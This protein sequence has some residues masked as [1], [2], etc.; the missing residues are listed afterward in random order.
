MQTGSHGPSG[1]STSKSAD[2]DDREVQSV[3]SH[4]EEEESSDE[5]DFDKKIAS[6]RRRIK[7][8]DCLFC[9]VRT[10]SVA[11]ILSHMSKSHS[12]FLPDRDHLVDVSGLLSYLGEKIV[13]GNI[14][15][16]CPHGGKEFGTLEGVRRHMID[17]AHCKLAYETEED[18]AEVLDFY[19]GEDGEGVDWEDVEITS[20]AD[21]SEDR[22]SVSD[23]IVLR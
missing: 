5:G 18:R 23:Y 8:T 15:I 4:D 2:V 12:F 19:A 17:K 21:E 16:Y 6:S 1:A 10:S 22:H 14:C 11:T 7:P 13:V 3:I 9:P 20:E